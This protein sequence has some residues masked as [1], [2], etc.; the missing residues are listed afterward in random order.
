MLP[1][2]EPLSGGPSV[3]QFYI[4]RVDAPLGVA[5]IAADGCFVTVES[6]PHPSLQLAL[7]ALRHPKQHAYVL[8]DIIFL[9]TSATVYA[10]NEPVPSRKPRLVVSAE[11]VQQ[12]RAPTARQAG[13]GGRR[14]TSRARADDAGSAGSPVGTPA[15][16][17]AA[18]ASAAASRA[19][20]LAASPT[21]AMSAGRPP[22]QLPSLSL[23]QAFS[24][25]PPCR[26][27]KQ[28]PQP[29]SPLSSGAMPPPAL[30]VSPP[31]AAE[32]TS[33]FYAAR[34]FPPLGAPATAC[35]PMPPSQLARAAQQVQAMLQH[36]LAVGQQPPPQRQPLQ[37]TQKS[38]GLLATTIQTPSPKRKRA[39][40]GSLSDQQVEQHDQQQQQQ[41]QQQQDAPQMQQPQSARPQLSQRQQGKQGPLAM[42]LPPP[43]PTQRASA[44]AASLSQP[45]QQQ[46]E[47]LQE[48]L[49]L[50]L[51]PC[52]TRGQASGQTP[53]ALPAQP[54]PPPDPQ[55]YHLAAEQLVQEL[56]KQGARSPSPP[57]GRGR[58]APPLAVHRQQELK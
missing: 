55:Q 40:E 38:T 9:P 41:Q 39:D 21:G 34:S 27:P 5:T 8:P 25:S 22:W 18:A 15:A 11:T 51:Q 50:S 14:M 52:G 24:T 53:T 54:L 12:A 48:E 10:L 57:N 46:E 20:Q 23:M 29:P 45:Q 33:P 26:R 2:P 42:R 32:A 43:Q 6:G 19:L 4:V 35:V 28:Q 44:P 47:A 1:S 13:Q 49:S 17:A 16:A 37:L 31:A 3:Q 36:Q 56:I 7:Q 58:P 30:P